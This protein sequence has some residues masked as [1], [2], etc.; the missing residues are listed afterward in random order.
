MPTSSVK[1]QRIGQQRDSNMLYVIV[2]FWRNTA[3][4][5]QIFVDTALLTQGQ[6][7]YL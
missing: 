4:F 7:E 5:Q 6:K 3:Q 1:F 2:I